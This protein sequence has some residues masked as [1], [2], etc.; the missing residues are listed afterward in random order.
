M[1]LANFF[2]VQAI[3]KHEDDLLVSTSMSSPPLSSSNTS[4][5]LSGSAQGLST[6]F[7]EQDSLV[8]YMATEEREIQCESGAYIDPL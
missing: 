2:C 7:S 3:H 1:N 6:L 5:S 4:T 8:S